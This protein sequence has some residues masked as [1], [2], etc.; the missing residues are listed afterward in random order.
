MPLQAPGLEHCDAGSKAILGYGVY[1][2]KMGTLVEEIIACVRGTGGRRGSWLACLNPH[3]YAIACDNPEF[4]TALHSAH[5]LVPDGAGVVLASR[6]LRGGITSRIT[7][8]DTFQAV[9]R[10]LDK[11]GPFTVLFMGSTPSTVG[12]VA[13]RYRQDF[14][15]ATRVDTFSPPF[16]DVFSEDDVRAM[17]AVI[18]RCAPDVLWVGLTA[19]KQELLLTQFSRAPAY[20][21]AAAIGAA[22]D[23]YAG[24]VNRSPPIFQR[25][26]LEWLPRLLQQ[27]RRLWRRMFVSAPRFL[28]HVVRDAL[29]R[30]RSQPRP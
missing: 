29:S 19:P 26:G 9:S 5:W 20:R 12:A 21:F 18:E 30:R 24:N 10:A 4:R 28:W 15:N 16:R 3:S 13:A 2:G 22:F 17:R 27:P 1:A 25:L 11:Q 7:G 6:M 8:P 14:Q 23:F